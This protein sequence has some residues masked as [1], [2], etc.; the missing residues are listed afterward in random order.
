MVSF[1]SLDDVRSIQLKI[2]EK[3]HDLFKEKSGHP[4]LAVTRIQ[5]NGN[6]FEK[7]R[8]VLELSHI[9]M[10]RN[11]RNAPRMILLLLLSSICEMFI[12]G[13]LGGLPSN[14]SNRKPTM[15]LRYSLSIKTDHG[16]L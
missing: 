2:D 13:P 11:V 9:K 4:P 10:L 16:Q 3:A 1:S 5:E 15:R 6:S 7:D 12:F 14:M 8:K